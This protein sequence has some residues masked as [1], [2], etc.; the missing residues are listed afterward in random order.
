MRFPCILKFSFRLYYFYFLA[1][2]L[3]IYPPLHNTLSF[4]NLSNGFLRYHRFCMPI[5]YGKVRV[6]LRCDDGTCACLDTSATGYARR[7][8][9][10]APTQSTKQSISNQ[11]KNKRTEDRTERGAAR[12]PAWALSALSVP[13]FFRLPLTLVYLSN[14]IQIAF[15]VCVILCLKYDLPC[16]VTLL[17]SARYFLS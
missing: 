13:I 2:N 5:R 12:W 15:D 16:I 10:H 1:A 3:T 4:T 17:R 9:A 6:C 8:Q 14:G 11:P 7:R